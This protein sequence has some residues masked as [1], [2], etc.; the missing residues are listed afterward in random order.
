VAA[1]A[2]AAA[3]AA[4]ARRRSFLAACGAGSERGGFDF[5]RARRGG[6]ACLHRGR[7]RGTSGG[8]AEGVNR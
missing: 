8:G 3:A 5:D 7:K 2:V 1:A 6:E 4:A